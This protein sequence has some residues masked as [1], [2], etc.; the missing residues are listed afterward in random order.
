M[1]IF[2]LHMSKV[3]DKNLKQ[4]NIL[5]GLSF[6]FTTNQ[7]FK[8]MPTANKLSFILLGMSI[9]QKKWYFILELFLISAFEYLTEKSINSNKGNYLLTIN[10]TLNRTHEYET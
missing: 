6:E 7:E 4:D 2:Y 5:N 8:Y 1:I 9:L 3:F 10:L